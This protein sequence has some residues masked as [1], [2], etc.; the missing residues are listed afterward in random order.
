MV[1]I[2]VALVVVV[3]GIPR[4]HILRHADAATAS[5][6]AADSAVVVVVRVLMNGSGS[7]PI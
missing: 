5:P 2:V 3:V 1:G 4:N 7:S 6:G